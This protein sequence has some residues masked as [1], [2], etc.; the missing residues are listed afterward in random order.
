MLLLTFSLG[1]ST[2]LGYYN[3]SIQCSSS[4]PNLWKLK[5]WFLVQCSLRVLFCLIVPQLWKP[6]LKFK[7]NTHFLYQIKS[8]TLFI[9]IWFLLL[10]LYC[11]IMCS[12][13]FLMIKF[14]TGSDSA[15]GWGGSS[16]V[17]A[18]VQ[19]VDGGEC[20]AVSWWCG[21]PRAVLCDCETINCF[22]VSCKKKRRLWNQIFTEGIRV[23]FCVN[24]FFFY[25]TGLVWL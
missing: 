14:L 10:D 21:V 4:I 3:S 6:K 19:S 16:V 12:Y 1:I 5:S 15:G 18:A 2:L 25:W 8:L 11:G 17:R 9:Q 23:I 24:F 13:F 22:F 7:F 20:G